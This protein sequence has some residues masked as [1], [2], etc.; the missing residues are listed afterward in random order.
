MVIG[1]CIYVWMLPKDTLGNL[2]AEIITFSFACG[3]FW[4]GTRLQMKGNQK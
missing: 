3:Y 2:Q 1:A 4:L